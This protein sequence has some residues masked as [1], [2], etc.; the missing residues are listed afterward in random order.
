M[1]HVAGSRF[2]PRVGE[3]QRS[4]HPIPVPEVG[5]GQRRADGGDP[6]PVAEGL[7]QGGLVLPAGGELRPHR[8]DRVIQADGAL[9]HELQDQQ[10]NEGLP[11]AVEI[12]QRV[13]FPGLPAGG[14]PP[15]SDQVDD[16]APVDEDADAGSDFAPFG[17]V[18][19]EFLTD[20]VEPRIADSE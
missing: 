17:E 2:P 9:V 3:R 11:D 12:D 4:G 10:G 7:P 15:A 8:G 18:P 20:P 19:G 1:V 5:I 13:G 6:R 14:A 16:D